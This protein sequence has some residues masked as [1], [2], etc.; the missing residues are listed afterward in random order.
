MQPPLRVVLYV[1]LRRGLQRGGLS[2]SSLLALDKQQI[3]SPVVDT[4][5]M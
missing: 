5:P 1:P 3:I 4:H 2:V